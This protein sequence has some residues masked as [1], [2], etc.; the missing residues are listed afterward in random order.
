MHMQIDCKH[1]KL[2]GGLFRMSLMKNPTNFVI[3]LFVIGLSIE[4]GQTQV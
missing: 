2:I 1:F 4:L 3:L